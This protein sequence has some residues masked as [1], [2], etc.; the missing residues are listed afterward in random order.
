MGSSIVNF[1]VFDKINGVKH[2]EL[3][4]D[5]QSALVEAQNSLLAHENY[6]FSVS[7][8]LVD[9]LNTTWKAVEE[10][11]F[12]VGDYQVFNHVTGGY[13]PFTTK[14]EAYARVEELKQEFL[15][16]GRLDK[17]YPYTPEQNQIRVA[18]PGEIV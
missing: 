16:A 11:D 15:I 8:V 3:E 18:V 13:E 12:E 4:S 10:T 1:T 7:I 17:V 14:T 5:A 9:G 2:F 6:R